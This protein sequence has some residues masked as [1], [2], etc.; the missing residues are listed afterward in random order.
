LWVIFNAVAFVSHPDRY[1]FI[2][3]NLMLSFQA[4]Y[5]APIIM[6]S[7][8]RQAAIDRLEAKHDYEVNVKAEL[9]IGLL[10]DKMNLL[11]E[12]ELVEL[13]KLLV[14]QQQQLRHME[15]LILEQYKKAI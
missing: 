10:H 12:Q 15:E 9:E 4:A 13:R 3:L 1:P 5:A 11:Q 6:M 14:E 2:L 8:N 7:Q